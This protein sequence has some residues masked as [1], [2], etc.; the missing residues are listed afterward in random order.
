MHVLM[1]AH[2]LCQH[3][4][5]AVQLLNMYSYF[6]KPSFK[7]FELQT[8][9]WLSMHGLPCTWISPNLVGILGYVHVGNWVS[10]PRALAGRGST[11]NVALTVCTK[12]TQ[13]SEPNQTDRTHPTHYSAPDGLDPPNP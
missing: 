9:I 5:V 6:N 1:S 7:S 2:C 4:A 12:P 10:R 11:V 3:P 13:A 8:V